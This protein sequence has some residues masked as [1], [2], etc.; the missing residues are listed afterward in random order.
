MPPVRAPGILHQTLDQ[1]PDLEQITDKGG[2]VQNLCQPITME[3]GSGSGSKDESGGLGPVVHPPEPQPTTTLRDIL[4]QNTQN[5]LTAISEESPA[6]GVLQRPSGSSMMQ[7]AP[8]SGNL[9][10]LG[11]MATLRSGGGAVQSRSYSLD[12]RSKSFDNAAFLP[13]PSLR[14]LSP[15]VVAMIG[16]TRPCSAGSAVSQLSSSWDSATAGPPSLLRKLPT[17]NKLLSSCPVD[18]LCST[19]ASCVSRCQVAEYAE[20][21]DE[22]L[23][24]SDMPASDPGPLLPRAVQDPGSRIQDL[25]SVQQPNLALLSGWAPLCP[26]PAS[27]PGQ[28]VGPGCGSGACRHDADDYAS[29]GPSALYEVIASQRYDG[30]TQQQV[31]QGARCEPDAHR[32]MMMT[33]GQAEAAASQTPKTQRPPKP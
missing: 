28:S 10:D 15:R 1:D 30:A 18:V 14:S 19:E 26:T 32:V 2:V 33:M 3:L 7:A 24:P 17:A 20:K 23:N 12:L 5:L 4:R 13:V 22:W 11:L 27:V 6:Y 16:I 21:Y 9:M 29:S 25:G 31:R 8:G